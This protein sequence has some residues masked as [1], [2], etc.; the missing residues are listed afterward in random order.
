V[1]TM[2]FTDAK[3][4][5]QTRVKH[6]D[7]RS[8]SLLS[9]LL[10]GARTQPTVCGGELARERNETPRNRREDEAYQLW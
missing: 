4:Q 6:S 2:F 10:K 1:R 5:L 7:T 3:L 9:R 8:Q